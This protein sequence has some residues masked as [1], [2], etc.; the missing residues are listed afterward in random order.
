MKIRKY[1]FCAL[2]LRH[3]L[4]SSR[5]LPR[6]CA[7]DIFNLC[8]LFFSCRRSCLKVMERLT[9]KVFRIQ[10]RF[11]SAIFLVDSARANRKARPARR[12]S[13]A[14]K[15]THE[16]GG[17]EAVRRLFYYK[18]A[19]RWICRYLLWEA[20]MQM[21]IAAAARLAFLRAASVHSPAH[22]HMLRPL[23]TPWANRVSRILNCTRIS[24]CFINL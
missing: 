15:K 12:C 24:V 23:R 10:S 5:S 21:P 3:S 11:I 6:S 9:K 16:Q 19:L 22:T 8:L 2:F 17:E 4:F 18:A 13:S 1:Y 20:L 14:Y 7:G